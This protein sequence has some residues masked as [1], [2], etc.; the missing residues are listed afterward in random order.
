MRV[1]EGV[2]GALGR[3]CDAALHHYAEP[4]HG[5]LRS[6]NPPLRA[7]DTVLPVDEAEVEL[8]IDREVELRQ[9]G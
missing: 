6:G 8:R 4:R 7:I 5:R 9:R 3:A 1:Q 2:D